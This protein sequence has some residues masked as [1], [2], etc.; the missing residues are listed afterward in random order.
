MVYAIEAAD[1]SGALSG[2]GITEGTYAWDGV[3]TLIAVN[4]DPS[5]TSFDYVD[6]DGTDHVLTGAALTTV[7]DFLGLETAIGYLP[8]PLHRSKRLSILRLSALRVSVTATSSP[9]V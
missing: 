5:A 1:I 3:D 4:E 6:S 2:L 9:T 8:P 7:S